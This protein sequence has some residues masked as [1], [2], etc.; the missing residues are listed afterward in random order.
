M[1]VLKAFVNALWALC[2]L[3]VRVL[4]IVLWGCLRVLV[5]ILDQAAKLI[6]ALIKP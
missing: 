6:E 3:L 1:D 2:K 5:V 4:A